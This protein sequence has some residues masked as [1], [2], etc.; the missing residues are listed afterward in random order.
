MIRNWRELRCGDY[1]TT[2][3]TRLAASGKAARV[4]YEITD[5]SAGY[6]ECRA[7]HDHTITRRETLGWVIDNGNEVF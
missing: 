6:V 2:A 5:I 3:T 7:I 4:V 1:F